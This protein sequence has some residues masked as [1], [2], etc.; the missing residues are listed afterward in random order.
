MRKWISCKEFQSTLPSRGATYDDIC[1]D[2]ETRISI[3]APLA[4]SDQERISPYFSP[5][6]FQSTLPSRGATLMQRF[7]DRE[8]IYF[9]PR[10]PRG[11]RPYKKRIEVQN[12]EFQST[13]PSRGATKE[14][15]KTYPKEFISIHA[16]LAGS[17]EVHNVIKL[18][19]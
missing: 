17:D 18:R 1:E 3:H 6:R 2:W 13:L 9:N 16:P 14:I 5:P 10:S 11:E 4:G 15:E 19:T 8:G 7:I 12:R